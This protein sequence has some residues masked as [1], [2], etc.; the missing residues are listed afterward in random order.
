M[1]VDNY[2]TWNQKTLHIYL[3]PR[4][5]KHVTYC[6]ADRSEDYGEILDELNEDVKD[7]LVSKMAPEKLAETAKAW[8]QMMWPT[9]FVTP[10]DLS[11]EVLDQ[12]DSMTVCV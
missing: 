2:K 3:K 5:A 7:A 9:F 4:L 8:T 10:D 1:S 6:A 11:R 12:M